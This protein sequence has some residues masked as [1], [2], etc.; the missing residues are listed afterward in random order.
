[1]QTQCSQE[2][3]NILSFI[4]PS[5][6][7]QVPSQF[8]QAAILFPCPRICLH[9]SLTENLAAPNPDNMDTFLSLISCW[10]HVIGIV[11]KVV[12]SLSMKAELFMDGN[13]NDMYLEV[14]A[15]L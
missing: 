2:T 13:I 9:F 6:F 10:C 3:L 15:S 11:D 8:K 7:K 14:P 4:C 1:M 12:S 5:Q